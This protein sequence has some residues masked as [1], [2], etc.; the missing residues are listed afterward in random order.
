MPTFGIVL[1]TLIF[2]LLGTAAFLGAFLLWVYS[3]RRA[4]REPRTIICPENLDFAQVTVDGEVAAR[5][6]L[7]GHEE[8]RIAACSR[9][10]E[11]QGCDQECTD[12]VPLVGDDRTHGQYAAFGMT[13]DQLRSVTPVR[14][15]ADMFG[16]VMRQKVNQDLNKRSA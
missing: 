8:F 7:A 9:W 13:P 6:A 14:M 1:Y 12:Q 3:E 16:K 2:F 10:P 11:M 5:T 15:T 4:Y